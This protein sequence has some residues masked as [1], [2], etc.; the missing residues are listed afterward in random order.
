[1]ATEVELKLHYFGADK[2]DPFTSHPLIR[3]GTE[4]A[5]TKLLKNT[6]FDTAEL[7]LYQERIALRIRVTPT[8]TLQ[9]IKCAGKSV[10]GLSSRPE[11]E[12]AYS[13]NFDFSEVDVA[14]VQTFLEKNRDHLIP[15]FT[16]HFDRRT[17][18]I[19]LSKKTTLLVMLDIGHIESGDRK[20]SISEVE[21]E[22]VQGSSR[23]LLEFATKLAR[24][25]PLIPSD[26]SKA[27]RGY[28]LYLNQEPR[29]KKAKASPIRIKHTSFDA[30]LLQAS[31]D[32]Q[33]LQANLHGMLTSQDPEYIH[34]YRVSLRR[35]NTLI[36]LFKPVL[37]ERFH[38]KWR[39]RIKVLTRTTGDLRD[40][41][42]L[43]RRILEP[44]LEDHD[45]EVQSQIASV[46]SALIIKKFDLDAQVGQMRYGGPV[47]LF[48]SELTELSVE[49]F[50]KNLSRFAEK[51]L[52]D[53]REKVTRRLVKLTKTPSPAN[54]HQLRIAIKHLRYACEFFAPL[55]NN[56]SV[57]E[58]VKQISTLQDQ[59]GTVNDFYVALVKIQDW[60]KSGLIHEDIYQTVNQ[61]HQESIQETLNNTLNNARCI[62][63][64][65]A[66]KFE[67]MLK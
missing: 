14:A 35:L 49:G 61:W 48:A 18:R 24:N 8:R 39:D 62:F 13:G 2:S 59:L 22:L 7:A 12:M 27:Q 21:L 16:T 26:M 15:I 54:A 5:P 45:P 42:V 41:S 66:E 56:A 58:F 11:W 10:A 32:M 38:N 40:L 46:L 30:F 17:W 65:D 33:M 44:M 64:N 3:G 36:R 6:Y 67:Q 23:D 20:L 53:L 52:L 43:Q 9:T 1:M 55:F 50:P 63:N 25:L 28:Q 34:Q 37:P 4:S 31:Q 51:R 19:E 29:P 47:L 57:L 60:I